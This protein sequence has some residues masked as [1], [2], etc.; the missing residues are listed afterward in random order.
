MKKTIFC[1]LILIATA[2]S[3]TDE[4]WK[5]YDDSH[6]PRIDITINPQ[7]LL[8]MYN[9]VQSDSEHV[10]T[11]RFKNNW[12]DE[13][14]DSIGFRIRGN[15]S[16]VSKKKSFKVSFNSFIKG[17]EF[18]G[19]DKLN[20]NGEHNDPSIIRAK[21][22]FDLYKDIGKKASRANHTMLYIND[23]Y[24]GLYIS[25]EH[26]DDE[27][28]EKNFTDDSGNLWKCLYPANL[29]FINNNPLTYKNL[30]SDG[31][32]VYELTTNE[33]VGDYSK[34]SKLIDVL[35]NTATP[36]LPDSLESILDVPGVLKYFAMNILLGSWDDYR[37][38]MNNY[39]L[40]HSPSEDKFHLL[41]YDYDN[42]FGIDWFSINWT[43]ANP[44]TFP[45]AVSGYRP[46]ADRLIENN[47][48]R[49]L[50]TRFL[51]FY[52]SE[53]FLLSKW[54]QRIENLK[55][56]ITQAAAADSFRTLDYG[57]TV[58][59]FLNS[60]SS[61]GYQKQHVKYG[62]KQFV[63]LRSQSIPSQ[64]NYKNALPIAYEIDFSPKYPSP[65]DSIFI[66]A[67]CFSNLGFNEVSI[68][69]TPDNSTS[70][71]IIP[72]TYKPVLNTKKVEEADRW[73]GVIPPLGEGKSGKFKI[74]LKDTQNGT[75]LYPRKDGI[76][77]K[78]YNY[79]NNSV[80]INE[81]MADNKTTIQDPSG[82]YED[83]IELHN[84]TSSPVLLTGRYLSDK[85]DNLTKW[86][87]TQPDLFINPNDYLLIWCDEN[88]SQT[89]IHTNF[90]LSAS[91]EFI[92]LTDIDGVTVI[93]SITFGL[94]SSDISF[95]RYPNAAVNFQFML[96]TP[97]YS[98]STLNINDEILPEGF[99]LNVYPNPFNPSTTIKYAISEAS[100]VTLKIF[101]VLGS[102]IWSL[103]EG[104]KTPGI[105]KLVWSGKSNAGLPAVSG[106]YILRIVAGK[107]SK[108]VKIML[109]K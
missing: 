49:D 22:S 39:Y 12:I 59:D 8:W 4:S 47:Q 1:L 65:T 17:R 23:K 78:T 89:G 73:I 13:V 51:S 95:G 9:N 5:L 27:F 70:T 90:K 14:V 94:Q 35:N 82:E 16:R 98:N 56:M 52:R 43:T 72:M 11:V 76:K 81:F 64:L 100:D 61:S 86:K 34:L 44:Y 71:Q 101:D 41:P 109:L 67:S 53:V 26:I 91:G 74:F 107:N 33:T 96:P 58:N 77:I 6:I 66:S 92:A 102:E 21:L 88:Q 37:S 57:Y 30:V 18:Y 63:N 3:Q 46:L 32:P 68:Y 24:Y 54:E 28:L 48:Y 87:F 106:N 79:L 62:L 105:H 7:S 15:T 36:A 99:S 19:V 45:K 20:L 83:W 75:V 103:S 55:N 31:R 104:I 97:G 85:P 2:L 10:A 29:V 93:D 40:Y 108:S 42:T 80:L 84:P 38:L 60:Y 50:F 69:Y 25:V